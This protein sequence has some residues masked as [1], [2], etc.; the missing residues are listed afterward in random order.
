MPDG[1]PHRQQGQKLIGEHPHVGDDVLDPGQ[2]IVVGKERG[3]GDGQPRY[4]GQ[5]GGGNAGGYGIDVDIPWV[6]WG[7]SW[8]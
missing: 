5:Q 2:Q 1:H 8:G 4:R 3:N 7:R 6:C